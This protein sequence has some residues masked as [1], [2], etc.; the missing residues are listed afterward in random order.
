MKCANCGGEEEALDYGKDA[1]DPGY[2]T[3]CLRDCVTCDACGL[4]FT[5][6][7]AARELVDGLC[8]DCHATT[9]RF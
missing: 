1:T 8:Q 4:R 3:T 6:E 5:R 7:D 2:C 9:D